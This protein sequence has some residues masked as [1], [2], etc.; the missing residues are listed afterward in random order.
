MRTSL[1]PSLDA[2]PFCASSSAAAEPHRP[3]CAAPCGDVPS[4]PSPSC[5]CA[6]FSSSSSYW[7]NYWTRLLGR[8]EQRR[9]GLEPD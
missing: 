2:C 1:H 4:P 7:R 5:A 3:C 9:L 6:P 8:E